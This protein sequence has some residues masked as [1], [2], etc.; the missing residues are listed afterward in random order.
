MDYQNTVLGLL[1]RQSTDTND[2]YNCKI[3][4]SL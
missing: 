3:T 2:M 4:Y 1:S